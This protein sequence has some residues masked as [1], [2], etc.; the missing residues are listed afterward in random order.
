VKL[1]EWCFFVDS[2]K[3]I[4]CNGI[5]VGRRLYEK[6]VSIDCDIQAQPVVDS[7]AVHWTEAMDRNVS[8]AAGHRDGN[9]LLLLLTTNTSVRTLLYTTITVIELLRL[10]RYYRRPN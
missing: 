2:P 6:H 4:N 1:L 10:N 9:L 7:V 8:L 3:F 5:E